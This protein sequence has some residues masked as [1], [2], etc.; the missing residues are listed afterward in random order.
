MDEDEVN[1]CNEKVKI[2]NKPYTEFSRCDVFAQLRMS[3]SNIFFMSVM[4]LYIELLGSIKDDRI[5]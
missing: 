5:D 3:S 1:T 4:L 2:P